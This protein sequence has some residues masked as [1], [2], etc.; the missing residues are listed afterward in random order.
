MTVLLCGQ[1]FVK[2]HQ[3]LRS[4]QLTVVLQEHARGHQEPVEWDLLMQPL[5]KFG[6]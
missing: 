4:A 5:R 6:Q 1:N 3:D 2:H